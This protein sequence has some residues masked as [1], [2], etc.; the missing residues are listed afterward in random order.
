MT[1]S[2]FVEKLENIDNIGPNIRYHHKIDPVEPKLDPVPALNPALSDRLNELGLDK[3]YTHQAEAIKAA[4]AG[5]NVIVA[6]PTASGKTMCY[7]APVVN[8]FLADP[9]STAIFIFPLKALEHDQLKS[10]RGLTEGLP[11]ATTPGAGFRAEIFDGDVTAH[12]RKKIIGALPRAIFTNPD[13]LHM[14]IM[15]YHG[16]WEAFFGKLKFIIID[17]AHTYRGVFG[18]HMAQVVRRLNRIADHYGAKPVFILSS[19][20]ISNPDQFARTLT[21]HEFRVVDTSGSPR[22][23]GHFIVYNTEGNPYTDSSRLFREAIKSGLKTIVFTKARKITELIYTWTAQADQELAD[24]ISCYRAGFLPEERRRIEQDLFSGALDGVVTT[25]ALEMGVDIGGLDVCVLVGY[26]GTII[27]TWQR[28]GRVGRGDREFLIILVAQ[29]DALDQY[30]VHHPTELFT[31]GFEAAIIDPDNISILKD[32]LVCAAAELPVKQ[33]D[34]WTASENRQ[35]AFDE[36][37]KERRLALSGDGSKWLSP[38]RYPHRDVPIRSLGKTYTIFENG[39]KT[40]I[41]HVSGSR[42]YS[43]CHVGAVY[44]HKGRQ[45]L[46]THLDTGKM[47]IHAKPMD[48]KYYTRPR[49]NKE[50]W[51]L[52]TMNEKIVNGFKIKLGR[53]KVTEQVVGYEKRSIYGQNSLGIFELDMPVTEFETVGFWIEIDD[54]VK[55]TI[56]Q[57]RL[58]YM[59]GIHAFEHGAIALFPLFALCDRN[60]IGGISYPVYPGL[61]CS[62]IFFYDGY[63]GGLGLCKAGFEKVEYLWSATLKLISDCDCDLGCPSCIHSPKCGSGNKPLDKQAAITVL[64]YVTG[65]RRYTARKTPTGDRGKVKD[66]RDDHANVKIA[67]CEADDYYDPAPE[68]RILFFDLETRKSAEDVGGWNNVHLMELAVGVVYDSMEKK[69]IRYWEDD[70]QKLIDKILSADLVVGFNH[71]WFDYGVLSGYSNVDLAREAKSFDILTDIRRR[72]GFRLSLGHLA[73]ATLGRR[74]TAD[75]LVSLQWWKEGEH[76]KVADYCQVDVEITKE[77]FEFGLEHDRLVY[78]LKSGET[79][80]LPLDWELDKIIAQAERPSSPGKRRIRF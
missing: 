79:A 12:H 67:A 36:L 26:P 38:R 6:T 43:E 76:D 17:E 50:T 57:S 5:E 35:T 73:Q 59:G 65:A 74:K 51:I 18:S 29:Q 32:H 11:S 13:M 7:T 62:A 33:D 4:V 41:G 34:R 70:V 39:G 19:A 21:G 58:G 49:T 24:R 27:N 61:G 63:P 25:S 64:E 54:A 71:V 20:T 68:Q 10:F 42:A 37:E 40:V 75:G 69:Y 47:V 78:T 2:S 56:E 48:E 52:E 72:L 1:V 30:F 14:S 22:P 44:L 3:L 31:R 55:E 66:T 77:L 9:D 23:G 53:L 46:V 16:K 60:D 8:E 15:P 45:Y 80:R 28:G